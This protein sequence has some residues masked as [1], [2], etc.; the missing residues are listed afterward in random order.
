MSSAADRRRALRRLGGLALSCAVLSFAGSAAGQS[1][2]RRQGERPAYSFEAEPHFVLG[3]FQPP[4]PGDDPGIGFGFRG[5]VEIV[6]D[7]FIGSIN[8]SVGVG[9]GADLMRFEADG[10]R[11]VCDDFVTGPNNTNV[12][13]EVEGDDRY[14]DYLVLPLVMQ[15]NFWLTRQWSVFGEPGIAFYYHDGDLDIDPVA[16]WGGGR[17][18]FSDSVSLTMRIGYPTLSVGFS[19]LL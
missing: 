7:G 9:F 17:F 5:T 13:V 2:I 1:T 8:D 15:W 16:L 19:F 12:C 18:H 11:G 3:A 10:A 6:P 4:G 14:A